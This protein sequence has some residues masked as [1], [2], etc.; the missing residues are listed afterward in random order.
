[1]QETSHLSFLS[2]AG[3]LDSLP[4]QAFYAKLADNLISENHKAFVDSMKASEGRARLRAMAINDLIVLAVVQ[5]NESSRELGRCVEAEV[6]LQESL[7]FFIEDP[8]VFDSDGIASLG[9]R[10]G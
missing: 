9:E 1:M 4:P 10:N 8:L 7:S 3:T 6:R 5:H 2:G